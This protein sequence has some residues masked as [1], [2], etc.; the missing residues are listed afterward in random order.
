[1]RFALRAVALP[2][3]GFAI[4]LSGCNEPHQ[5]AAPAAAVVTTMPATLT[6]ELTSQSAV[7]LNDGSR[8]Q[9]FA[10]Q[11]QA[12]TFYRVTSSGALQQPLLLL[13][14]EDNR[15]VGGP[16]AEKLYIQPEQDGVYRLAVSGNNAKD[17]GPFQLEVNTAETTNE[18][19][20]QPGADILG[21]LQADGNRAGNRYTLKIADKGL[22]EILLRSDEFD[23]VLKLRG[24]GINLNDDDGAGNTDSRLFTSLEAGDYQL[25]AEGIEGGEEGVYNLI[26]TQREMPE[27]IDL[28]EGARLEVGK[29]Y[30]GLLAGSAQTYRLV[31]EESGLLELSMRSQDMDSMLELHGPGV[32][33][34][35]D[36]SGGD[37]DAL[38][39][40]V[41]EPGTY[42]VKA[43]Q[44]NNQEGVFTLRGDITAVAVLG[45][46]IA[47]TET[48][49]GRLAAGEPHISRLRI[50]EAGLYRVTLRSSEFDAM[51]QL[52][53]Q[54]L[55]EED[56]DSAGGSNAMLELYLE[57]GEY[58]LVNGSYGDEGQGGFVLSVSA[59]L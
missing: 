56:D 9:S 54:G 24:K 5:A 1:M 22:Y 39:S 59:P 2:L 31:V 3:A 13:L 38:I 20:L 34:R 35:D 36:D 21:R 28:S 41:V 29:E 18:G 50:A 12:D 57:A 55:N 19:E 46:G 33:V 26:V 7:N 48:R 51:L 6:G 11:L 16:R 10:L 23:T 4:L 45:D 43:S 8:T 47:P 37:H 14:T 53:G 27:G 32:A 30:T 49:I 42:R 17:F 15:P 44:L 58:E 52:Q 25:S 40:A